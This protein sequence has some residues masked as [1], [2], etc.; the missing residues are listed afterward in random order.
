METLKILKPF[1]PSVIK[2]KIP[3]QIVFDLNKYIDEVVENKRK[4]KELNHGKYLVGDVTQEIKLE[5]D[6]MQKS[7][8]ANFL[9][10]CTN[11]WV[12]LEFKKNLSKF[13]IKDSWIVRQFENEYNPTHWH[14]GHISG[15]GFLKIPKQMGQHI[16]TEKKGFKDFKGGYLELIH[17]ARMFA[18]DS[19]MSINPQVGDFYIFPHYLMH[20]VFPFRGTNEERRSISF[21]AMIDESI[22][23]VY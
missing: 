8:W 9:A 11:Q 7:G 21:N 12:K 2:V 10:A 14:D 3:E 4:S 1:G 6:I 16:Q 19:K 23:E 22:Y 5:K 13:M 15:A 18:C 20:S 17:G